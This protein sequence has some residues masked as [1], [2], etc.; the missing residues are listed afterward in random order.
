MSQVTEAVP[1]LSL[2]GSQVLPFAGP[3][4]CGGGGGGKDVSV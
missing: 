3:E 4:G 1:W 2:H